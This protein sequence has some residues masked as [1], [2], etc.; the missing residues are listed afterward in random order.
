[1]LAFFFTVPAH[2]M[3]IAISPLSAFSY[4][5]CPLGP[6]TSFYGVK[7]SPGSV[8]LETDVDLDQSCNEI[9]IP[10]TPFVS[11]YE[12]TQLK[13]CYKTDQVDPFYAIQRGPSMN[14][15][16]QSDPNRSPSLVEVAHGESLCPQNSRCR[17]RRELPSP[18]R[19]QRPAAP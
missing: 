16:G 1:M 4:F 6:H 8:D 11:G 10:L 13:F 19:D 17:R 12:I 18:G 14:P 3:D 15:G 2:A 5:G 7:T 9:Y